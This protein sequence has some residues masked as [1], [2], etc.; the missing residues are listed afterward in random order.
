MKT[1]IRGFII[2]WIFIILTYLLTSS[3]TVKD[4]LVGMGFILI[5]I[6]A[7]RYFPM[8]PYEQYKG[9]I[10]FPLQRFSKMVVKFIFFVFVIIGIWIIYS[11]IT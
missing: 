9:T 7:L 8:S 11:V 10:W 6:G 1:N 2:I 3:E 5:G 4:F